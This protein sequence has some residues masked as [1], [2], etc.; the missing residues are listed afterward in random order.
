[1]EEIGLLLHSKSARTA[2]WCTPVNVVTFASTG[3]DGVHFSLLDLGDGAGDSSPVVMTV[4]VADRVQ[5]LAERFAVSL[6]VE[7]LPDGC[8]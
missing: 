2:Y 5:Q 4:R 7:D 1:M 6:V 3:G 8:Y